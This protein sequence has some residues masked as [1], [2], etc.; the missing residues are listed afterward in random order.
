MKSSLSQIHEL[1]EKAMPIPTDIPKIY[2]LGDT[3][4]GK[5][6]LISQLLGTKHEKFPS[7]QAKRTT[8]TTTEFV[9]SRE[10]PF[11]AA[12]VFKTMDEIR[13]AIEEV[14]EKA[15]L[16]STGKNKKRIPGLK[17]LTDDLGESP[18]Q[19]FRL[20]YLLSSLEM[21]DLAQKVLDGL[22]PK[23]HAE[24]EK[25]IPS[26]DSPSDDQ[27]S[28]AAEAIESLSPEIQQYVDEI[29]TKVA[30]NLEE[31]CPGLKLGD[32]PVVFQVKGLTRDELLLKLKTMLAA[33]KNSLSPLVS[34]AR[35]QGG[36]LAD[37]LPEDSAFVLIDGEGVGHTAA[38]AAMLATRH[39]EF[40]QYANTILLLEE[41]RKPF[42]SGAINIIA[43]I[44]ENGYYPKFKLAFSKMDE[45]KSDEGDEEDR[46]EGENEIDRKLRS[47]EKEL[48]NAKDALE[49]RRVAVD[50]DET[51]VFYLG[52]LGDAEINAEAKYEIERMVDSI[53]EDYESERPLF[54]APILDFEML[55]AYILSA[56]QDFRGSWNRMLDQKAWQS[57]KAFNRRM[58]WQEAGYH[59]MQPVTDFQRELISKLGEML[60]N[61]KDWA[62]PC[63]IDL[64]KSSM[65]YLRRVLSSKLLDLA[66]QSVV[67]ENESEWES[68]IIMRGWGSTFR[69]KDLIKGVMNTRIPRLSESGAVPFKD[70]IKSLIEEA[71]VDCGNA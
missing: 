68:G 28:A 14:L 20:R 44:Y 25:A 13:Q 29:W 36:Y 17:D 50:F 65:Q 53:S 9:L 21:N 70:K 55:S 37:W 56:S 59:D 58:F 66:W 46:E 18:D 10:L 71:I 64:K 67:F 43:G 30:P 49:K 38:E 69:R 2:L 45:M 27:T 35:V 47:L 7:V 24:L 51:Q 31:H 11:E 15:I 12:I 19:R 54:I 39:L 61:P 23:F 22:L 33:G 6:T 62:A 3:G 5:T 42:T 26:A 57:I 1:L 41:S 63:T 40:F 48:R 4:A 52:G 32:T 60:Q 8:V 16:N 34:Y